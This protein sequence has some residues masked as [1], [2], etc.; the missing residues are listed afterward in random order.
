MVVDRASL[1][2][3][4]GTGD[5]DSVT[6]LLETFDDEALLALMTNL[7]GHCV[8]TLLDAYAYAAT[9]PRPTLFIAYTIKSY[10][11]PSAGHKDNHSGLMNPG[12][13][14]ELRHALGIA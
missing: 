2:Q 11:L 6:A 14:D 5:L 3:L 13:V 8:E 9:G 12:Q 7:G 10:G 4:S 1:L